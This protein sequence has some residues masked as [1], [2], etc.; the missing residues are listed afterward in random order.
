[1]PDEIA[2]LSEAGQPNLFLGRQ[3]TGG[4]NFI[5]IDTGGIEIPLLG[6]GAESLASIFRILILPFPWSEAVSQ[7]SRTLILGLG[8]IHQGRI[9]VVFLIVA[10]SLHRFGHAGTYRRGTFWGM[11]RNE[12]PVHPAAHKAIRLPGATRSQG[13]AT[14]DISS[15]PD[16]SPN[17]FFD[18]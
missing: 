9:K 18:Y 7:A 1:M 16:P 4:A 12:T 5:E 8:Q 11:T 6:S 14:S 13:I 15:P 17:L 10:L 2:R 3:Q